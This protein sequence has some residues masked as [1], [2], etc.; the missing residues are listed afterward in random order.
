MTKK[1]GTDLY[2]VPVKPPIKRIK[3][4]LYWQ[5][6]LAEGYKGF[7]TVQLFAAFLRDNP[8]LAAA[9]G[10]VDKATKK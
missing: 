6:G 7:D 9:V 1:S 8:D 10:Y 2:K 5:D 3:I 4:E